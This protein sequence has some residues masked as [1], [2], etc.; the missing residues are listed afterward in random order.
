MYKELAIDKEIEVV[1]T[2]RELQKYLF[3]SINSMMEC[4]EENTKEYSKFLGYMMGNNYDEIV[5][6]WENMTANILF[7]REDEHTYKIIF[8]Y[9]SFSAISVAFSVRMSSASGST[10]V[11][12]SCLAL[13]FIVSIKFIFPLFLQ[14][15]ISFMSLL[16]I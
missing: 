3:T 10:I 9:F 16:Y 11:F 1:K 12:I 2:I 5:I 15:F 13:S 6:M 7:K 4:I 14:N 8:A